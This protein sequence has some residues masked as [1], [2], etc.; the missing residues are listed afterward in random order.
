MGKLAQTCQVFSTLKKCNKKTVQR[1]TWLLINILHRR[2]LISYN[3]SEC[4][5]VGWAKSFSCPPS[6]L[7]KWCRCTKKTLPTRTGLQ[8]SEH[9]RFKKSD[10]FQK[11]D[12]YRYSEKTPFETCP[13]VKKTK[14]DSSDKICDCS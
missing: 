5:H 3:H 14:N 10:F 7:K 12:F 11:S 8:N 2:D 6:S 13:C 4:S 9:T 1:F